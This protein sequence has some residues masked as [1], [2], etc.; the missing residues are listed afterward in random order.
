ML[1]ITSVNLKELAKTPQ[2]DLEQTVVLHPDIIFTFG[3]GEADKDTDKKLVQ[4]KIPVAISVDHLEES[5][6]ARAEWIKFFA[7]FVNKK[8]EADS[9]FKE[10]EKNYIDLK[11][12]AQKTGSKPTV[13][14]EIKYGDSWYM[15]GGKSYVAQL[16]NDAGSTYLWKDDPKFGSLPLSFEQ[17]YAKAKN[18]RFLDQPFYTENKKRAVKF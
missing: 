13:F 3:M 18:R 10:V 17:V 2:I 5:P 15:P 7:A 14:N 11:A 6:L 16:L 4:T 8:R 9:I 12:T 1:N